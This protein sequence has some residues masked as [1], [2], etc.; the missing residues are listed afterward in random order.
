MWK[1][2]MKRKAARLL[3]SSTRLSMMARPSTF[4]WPNPV[5][6]VLSAGL[7]VV[8][9][10][11]TVAVAS[12]VATVVVLVATVVAVTVVVT[13]TVAASAATVVVIAA[14]TVAVTTNIK[15]I[16]GPLRAKPNDNQPAGRK[17]RGFT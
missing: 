8:A 11:A 2:R 15:M 17:K 10:V 16:S 14:V 7:T 13:A 1:W 4:L 5:K 6:S 9:V 3:K 12:V